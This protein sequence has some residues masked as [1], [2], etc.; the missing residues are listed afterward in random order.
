MITEKITGEKICI[1]CGK[2]SDQLRIV[3]MVNEE[4]EKNSELENLFQNTNLMNVIR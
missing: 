3:T 4:K 1:I 2:F